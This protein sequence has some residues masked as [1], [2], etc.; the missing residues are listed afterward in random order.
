MAASGYKLFVTGDVLTAAQ[1]NDYLMLQTV[2][3]FASSAARTTALSGVLAE[4]LTSYLKDTNSFEIYDGSGWVSYGSGDITAVSAGTGISVA[5]GTGPVPVVTNS[6]ATEITAAGDII[7]GTGSGTFDNLPIGTTAQVLTA[8]TTVSPYKVKWATPATS[9]SGLTLVKRSTFSNVATT[10]TTFDGVFTSTYKAYYVVYEDMQPNAGSQITLLFQYRVSGSTQSA[11]SYY[12]GYFGFYTPSGTSSASWDSG[13]T[14]AKL[15]TFQT[16]GYVTIGNQ[17][18][19]KVGNGS[20]GPMQNGMFYSQAPGAPTVTGG[21]YNAAIVAD[22]F[23]LS[24]SSNF[25]G[26]VA[27]YGL[28]N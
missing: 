3:V 23:I 17:L 11:A 1:V 15:A 7:V 6:M 20:Q 25:S 19:T 27:I 14:S 5:S 28:A 12:G 18:I 16:G 13:S 22:G 10:T 8:D 9:A 26:T 4:G 24:A 21:S 2:M